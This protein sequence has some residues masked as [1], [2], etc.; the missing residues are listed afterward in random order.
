MKALAKEMKQ[1][2]VHP[3]L[4]FR[5]LQTSRA[6][7]PEYL[8]NIG[9]VIGDNCDGLILDP[10]IPEVLD[11]CEGYMKRFSDWGY[12]IVKHDFTS[13]DI[14]G[15]WGF[16]RPRLTEEG[17]HFADTSR[18]TAEITLDLYRALRKGA[19]DMLI[20]GCNTF[21]HLAAGYVEMMR[22]G[23]DTSGKQWERTRKMGINALAFRM[24]QHNTFYAADPDCVGLTPKVPWE[25]NAQFLD[26]LGRSGAVTL[27]SADPRAMGPQQNRAVAAAFQLAAQVQTPAEPLDWVWN[28]TPAK[29]KIGSDVFEY[30]W[31][32]TSK[33]EYMI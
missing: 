9:R 19:G 17:W 28:A 25:L 3:G 24:P 33:L 29:W 11:A 14:I 16:K 23:D 15:R 26:L 30:D 32:D 22:T 4:W 1:E 31:T 6:V 21:S 8:L 5:P 13:Y 12:E 10:S 27:I 7:P 20:I 2:G 18:T